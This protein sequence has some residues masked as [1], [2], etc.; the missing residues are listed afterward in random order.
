MRGGVVVS[1]HV[2]TV[3]VGDVPLS[4]L[5]MSVYLLGYV[6]LHLLFHWAVKHTILSVLIVTLIIGDVCSFAALVFVYLC[7]CARACV[8]V[9]LFVCARVCVCGGGGGVPRC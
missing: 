6:F 5:T 3:S 4:H 9:C 1:M 7:V 8:F 2:A